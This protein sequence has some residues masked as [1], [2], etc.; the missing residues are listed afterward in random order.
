M[1]YETRITRLTVGLEGKE[2]YDPS[3]THIEIED[4]SGGEFLVLTQHPD[5]RG[6]EQTLRF[7]PKEWDAVVDAVEQLRKGMR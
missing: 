6:G 2:I 3:M 4:E 1:K 7:D 5:D